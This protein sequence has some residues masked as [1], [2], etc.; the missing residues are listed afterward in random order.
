[1][2]D[3]V[4]SAAVGGDGMVYV[5]CYNH[6]LYALTPEGKLDWKFRTDK[7]ISAAPTLLS[8]GRLLIGSDDGRLYCLRTDS[9]GLSHSP[10][11]KFQRDLGNTGAVNPASTH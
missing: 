1:M 5:G 8:D 4:R 2:L 6:S 9:P 11:P 7:F 10:W 3:L